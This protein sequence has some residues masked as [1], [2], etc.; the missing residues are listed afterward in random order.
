MNSININISH[1]EH[2]QEFTNARFTSY[3]E[4]VQS[5]RDKGTELG[6]ALKIM[7]QNP[8]PSIGMVFGKFLCEKGRKA[9][10][11][12]ARTNLSNCPFKAVV[13]FDA[14]SALFKV[15]ID[16][17]N[18]NHTMRPP[19]NAVAATNVALASRVQL[20]RHQGLSSSQ[21]MQVLVNEGNAVYSHLEIRQ[22]GARP[23]AQTDEFTRLFAALDEHQFLYDY[24]TPVSTTSDSRRLLIHHIFFSTPTALD[25]FEKFPEVILFDTTYKT[26]TSKMPLGAF[27][28]VD[29]RNKSFLIG[30][31]LLS[32]EKL[33]AF[34]FGIRS[35]L[36]KSR[37]DPSRIKTVITDY[38]LQIRQA[39]RNRLPH[40]NLLVCRWHVRKN[41]IDAIRIGRRQEAR[42]QNQPQPILDE[43]EDNFLAAINVDR[44]Q[45]QERVVAVTSQRRSGRR[46][47]KLDPFEVAKLE[48]NIMAGQ[49]TE[50]SFLT[51]KE[52]FLSKYG[53]LNERISGWFGDDRMA[54][55]AECYTR[56]F[57]RLGA[58][59]T[60]RA[61][62]SHSALKAHLS[63][64][65]TLDHL[66]R[67][68]NTV[69]ISTHNA[70][71][72]SDYNDSSFLPTRFPTALAELRGNVSNYLFEI[73]M[74]HDELRRKMPHQPRYVDGS[75][76]VYSNYN[77]IN[78]EGRAEVGVS[79]H[80]VQWVDD[81]VTAPLCQCLSSVSDL[82]PC[83]HEYA[84][85][86]SQLQAF[87]VSL[88]NPRWRLSG[89]A[90]IVEPAAVLPTPPLPTPHCG[91][92]WRFPCLA[93][94]RRQCDRGK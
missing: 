88:V 56:K 13:K 71:V 82:F 48:F 12:T 55:W 63:G 81:N 17:A 40:V 28:G 90:P 72:K 73:F 59:T 80:N 58:T 92:C 69:F 52:Q 23:T 93:T 62:S 8:A 78:Q 26:S 53:S 4:A 20:L 86:V 22:I 32:N 45:D 65:S 21:V 64:A 9:P 18:H 36:Q 38:D 79:F 60:S 34:E 94:F 46:S 70:Y 25:L 75:I 44:V 5:L 41:I 47:D 76:E 31:I 54:A 15:I 1:S 35:L 14:D 51:S 91:I 83:W 89:V 61:E 66:V 29:N 30:V 74:G 33:I 49:K 27:V 85:V 7:Y 67:T 77:F 16:N 87:P 39:F 2:F 6:F 84:A 42:N 57:P 10:E 37:V 68:L 43:N 50:E 19:T 24:S 11:Y 3:S